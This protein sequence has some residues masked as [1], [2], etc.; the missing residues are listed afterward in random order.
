MALTAITPH[1]DDL[2]NF[3]SHCHRKSYPNRTTIIYEGGKCDTLYYII[4]GSVSVVL[5]EDEGKEVVITYFY[6]G[7]FFG[8]MGLFEKPEERSASCRTRSAC[9]IAEISYANFNTYI[10]SHPEIVFTIGQQIAHRLRNTTRKVGD[11]A[12]YDVSGRIAR[13]LI[14]LSKE[15][16]AMTHPNG[17]Q[18]KI[19]R[20]EIG[21]LV[22]CS[23]EMAGRV[24]KT[25]EEQ[26]LIDVSGKTIVVFGA[27]AKL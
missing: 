1:I 24:L 2:D 17:M 25:L 27:R 5:E 9:E 6:P 13:T 14:N 8:E 22:N 21:R 18:I 4:K 11:L 20:Q 3:L 15:P 10:S 26:Q 19:T 7:D 12:F 16:D 23:R